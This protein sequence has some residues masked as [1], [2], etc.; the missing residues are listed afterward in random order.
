MRLHT[1]AFVCAAG[2]LAGCEM[3]SIESTEKPKARRSVVRAVMP[4]E[5]SKTATC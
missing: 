5:R 2:V 3:L 1:F 4:A